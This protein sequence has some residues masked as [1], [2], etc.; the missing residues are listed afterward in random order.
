MNQ[1]VTGVTS[2]T[3]AFQRGY[4]PW[5]NPQP[6][7]QALYGGAILHFDPQASARALVDFVWGELA[8]AFPECDPRQAQFAL[9]PQ[10][11]FARVSSLRVRLREDPRSKPLI[12]AMLR[13]FGCDL[14]QAYC[15]FLRLR[16]VQSDGHLNPAASSAY[17][18]HRDNWYANPA[19]QINWWLPVCDVAAAESPV[20]FPDHFD[21]QIRNS[22]RGF[23]Y[24]KWKEQ[25]GWQSPNSSKHFPSVL[26]PPGGTPVQFEAKAGEVVMFS[27]THLHGT[28]PHSTGKTRFSIEVRVVHGPDVEPLRQTRNQDN[29]SRGHAEDDYFNAGDFS[30]YPGRIR[31]PDAQQ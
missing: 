29:Q 10:E 2:R 27:G 13:E 23:D 20:F 19:A 24:T 8:R 15:D 31:A 18:L 1:P 26:E 5:R 25:G 22:S 7:L 30:A 4:L 6:R 12:R 3:I 21:R 28:A 9:S 14:T 17:L 11:F 16:A